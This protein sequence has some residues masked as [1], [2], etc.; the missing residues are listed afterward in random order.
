MGTG[1]S[2][3][4]FGIE[5]LVASCGIWPQ[6]L[7]MAEGCQGCCS[8]LT[9]TS[10]EWELQHPLPRVEIL[11]ARSARMAMAGFSAQMRNVICFPD[12]MCVFS[13]AW[14]QDAEAI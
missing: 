10:L 13:L 2:C 12:K 14:A 5:R 1:R 8:T 7:A 9:T 4:T 3:R 11:S 6:L